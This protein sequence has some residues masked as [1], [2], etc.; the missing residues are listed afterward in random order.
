[1]NMFKARFFC[2]SRKCNIVS[3]QYPQEL[4]WLFF[5]VLHSIYRRLW[6]KISEKQ[7][8]VFAVWENCFHIQF[9]HS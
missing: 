1:M 2:N 5:L 7:Y 6:K 8:R 4:C 3:N 9:L